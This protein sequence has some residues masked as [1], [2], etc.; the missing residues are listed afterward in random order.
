MAINFK[1]Y[2][3]DVKQTNYPLLA[4]LKTNRKLIVLFHRAG[5]GTVLNSDGVVKVA[6]Y[7]EDW[8]DISRWEILP[9]ESEVILKNNF[10]YDNDE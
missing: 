1:I 8:L 7:H 9:K 6:S 4:R 3:R 5:C 2:E 10:D